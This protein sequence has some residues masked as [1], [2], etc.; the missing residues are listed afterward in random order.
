M[1]TTMPPKERIKLQADIYRD[2]A[3][4]NQRLRAAYEERM[5]TESSAVHSYNAAD[6]RATIY[7]LVATKLDEILK[8]WD[9]LD[10]K[11]RKEST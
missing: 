1:R 10:E 3:K 6:V 2:M 9:E 4:D 11:E 8:E 7:E 5:K